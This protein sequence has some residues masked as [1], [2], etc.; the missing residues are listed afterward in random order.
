MVTVR[1]WYVFLVCFIALQGVTWA[2]I[3]LLRGVLLGTSTPL[4]TAFQIAVTIIGLPV[5]LGH[6]VWAERLVERDADERASVLRRL[7][8]YGTLAAFLA[9]IAVDTFSL[10][11]T[12]L[13]LSLGA[14]QA[15]PDGVASLPKERIVQ[16]LS[17]LVVLWLLWLY[18]WRILLRDVRRVPEAGIALT[19]RRWYILGFSAA[20]LV[21]LVS[22]MIEVLRW[23]LFQFGDPVI[24]RY[25]SGLD[26]LASGV[27][28][29]VVG[30]LVWV[31]FWRWAQQLFAEPHAGERTSVLRSFYLYASV[32]VAV[33]TT[34]TNITMLL[35]GFL[36]RLLGLEPQG[37][38]RT[39]VPIVVVLSCVWVYHTVVL[40]GDA[41][42]LQEV[43]R[44]ADLRRL[45]WYL[46]AAVGLAAMLVGLGGDI[47]VLIRALAEPAVG[48]D[49]REQLAWYS[50]ALLAGVP[51]WGWPWRQAQTGAVAPQ[52]TGAA[53]RRSIVRKI[54]LYFYLFV[55]TMTVLSSLIYIVYRVL[56][57]VLGARNT[58]SL[59]A[60]LAQAIAFALIAAG[61]W[62][63]H[64]VTL[65][66]DGEMNQ[67]DQAQRLAAM[68]VAVV[69]AG[70]GVMGQAVLAGLQQA[71]PDLALTP[72]GLTPAAAQVMGANVALPITTL[73]AEVGVIVGS[74]A[75]VVPAGDV[76]EAVAS[77]IAASPAQKVL[78]PMRAEGWEW[79]GVERWGVDA[80][81]QQT[82]QAIKQLAVGEAVQPVH[83]L[84][85]AGVVGI[86]IGA[87]LVLV[88]LA[89]PVLFFFSNF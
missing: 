27:A 88:M 68:Q 67:R 80:V 33:L 40:R 42:V 74:W 48:S 1:R 64:N 61:V 13:M 25:G 53:E 3:A 58:G 8:L 54:Y 76:S 17:A 77:A 38:V 24:G 57:V 78:I 56:S 19:V 62:L 65:R 7:Y 16:N 85:A 14:G 46:V 6:W 63:Y 86:I 69:D 20:G 39:V 11:E 29:L 72:V 75:I 28:R 71:F 5:F 2:V 49:M 79:V 22:A 21:A 34:V 9:P 66:G 30:V 45:Y 59:L 4:A 36:R 23:I 87:V 70:E 89:V 84:S 31:I 82:V 15:S 44:Q 32:F 50:A 37:D 35:A 41:A 10:L 73:L 47:S 51:V 52:A 26:A 12:L 81:V 83:S 43:P 55:A 18:H 60:D